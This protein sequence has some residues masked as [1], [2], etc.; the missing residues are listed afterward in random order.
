LAP[1]GGNAA[2]CARARVLQV[3]ADALRG[4]VVVLGQHFTPSRIA[5]TW[6][7]LCSFNLRPQQVRPPHL[8]EQGA[9][10][11]RPAHLRAP[12][13]PCHQCPAPALVRSGPAQAQAPLLGQQLRRRQLAH[14]AAAAGLGP[15]HCSRRVPRQ[16]LPADLPV[17]GCGRCRCCCRGRAAH[18]RR[19]HPLP[20][21]RVP[22][23]GW[24]GGGSE[25]GRLGGR[26]ASSDVQPSSSAARGLAA[27]RRG[28]GRG[29][30]LD[31]L[32]VGYHGGTLQLVSVLHAQR[33]R[34]LHV[35]EDGLPLVRLSWGPTGLYLC[36]V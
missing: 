23:S 1:R 13:S 10:C 7:A 22:P 25:Q 26:A 24:F 20:G 27:P 14:R 36:S 34:L 33:A 9:T 35:L 5:S 6:A 17:G 12:A 16:C 15:G 19:L 2:T 4:G 18:P 31:L 32:K 30:H 3:A 21:G 28:S 11:Q 8:R 29:A